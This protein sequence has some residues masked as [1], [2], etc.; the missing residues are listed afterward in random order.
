MLILCDRRE[1]VD[2]PSWM[3]RPDNGR[4]VQ[5]GN[6]AL[7]NRWVVPYNPLLT[8]V[9]D[10]HIN[11]EICTGMSAVKYIYKYVHKG[12]DRAI[13]QIRASAAAGAAFDEINNFVEG[14]Y[15]SIL[16]LACAAWI[17]NRPS[18]L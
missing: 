2:I 11:V 15:R 6:T 9:F 18:Q 14:R 5:K 13:A 8:Q 17:A 1:G 12:H 7:D 10:C 16:L 4:S 3:R